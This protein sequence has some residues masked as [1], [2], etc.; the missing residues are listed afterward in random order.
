MFIESTL[1]SLGLSRNETR[2]YLCLLE[3]G[4]ATGYQ[5]SKRLDMKK[6]TAYL[7][8]EE[9]RKKNLARR[10]PKA[11]R[12]VFVPKNPQELITEAHQRV[13]DI[14]SVVPYLLSLQKN[15]TKPNIVFY[16]GTDGMEEIQRHMENHTKGQ[17][18]Y[19]FYAYDENPPQNVINS[20]LE[21]LGTFQKNNTHL[22][23]I[24]PNH[25]GTQKFF[26][27]HYGQTNWDIRYLPVTLLHNKVSVQTNGFM[28]WVMS[29]QKDQAIMIENNDIADFVINVFELIWNTTKNT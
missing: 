6:A 8:L 17:T 7:T 3:F 18:L 21:H 26:K 14:E 27:Y 29:R 20:V 2:V 24:V 4:E 9:L 13:I 1:T 28:T 19:S 16:E 5:V 15:E 23:I 22:K 11:T 12:H 10:I 25:E